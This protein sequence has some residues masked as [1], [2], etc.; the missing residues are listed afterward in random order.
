MA[1]EECLPEVCALTSRERPQY[2]F[3]K[4]GAITL[5]GTTIPED[6]P[7][8]SDEFSFKNRKRAETNY[9]IVSF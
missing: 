9:N 8:C 3:L 7:V 1:L 5:A 6:L 4:I 2:C